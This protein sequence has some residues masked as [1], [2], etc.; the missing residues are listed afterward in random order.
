MISPIQAGFHQRGLYVP[1]G[2]RTA[3]DDE[4]RQVRHDR[5][6]DAADEQLSHIHGA[7]QHCDRGSGVPDDRAQA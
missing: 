2:E 4:Y 6:G 1:P 3:A 5:V 7:D